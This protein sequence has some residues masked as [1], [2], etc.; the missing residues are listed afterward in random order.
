M[1]LKKHT[2][3]KMKWKE[4]KE[5]TM[6]TKTYNFDF[7]FYFDHSYTID[8]FICLSGKKQAK[9]KKCIFMFVRP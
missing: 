8:C 9:V 6:I 4:E 7:H 2:E 3:S 1:Q 5:E